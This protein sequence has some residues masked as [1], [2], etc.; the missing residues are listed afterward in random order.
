LCG[1][2]PTFI[3]CASGVGQP[4]GIIPDI[5]FSSFRAPPRDVCPPA[6]VLGL[7]QPAS[8]AAT[9][10]SVSAPVEARPF[11]FRKSA[12]ELFVGCACGVGHPEDTLSDMRRARAR[13]AQIGTPD[14]ISQC[15]QV[16]TYSGEPFTSILARNLLSNDRWRAALL[17]E[18]QELGPQMTLVTGSFASTGA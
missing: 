16:S 5:S 1:S 8:W 18:T 3:A 2:Q 12:G 17:N 4:V 6:I 11:R 13:S 9:P 14:C 10:I 15:F 7:G